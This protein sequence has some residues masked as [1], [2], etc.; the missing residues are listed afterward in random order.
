MRKYLIFLFF[1]NIVL[2][3]KLYYNYE[4]RLFIDNKEVKIKNGT[5]NLYTAQVSKNG[6]Y[7]AGFLLTH[8]VNDKIEHGKLKGGII[9]PLM[10]NNPKVFVVYDLECDSVIYKRILRNWPSG[11]FSEN[12]KYFFFNGPTQKQVIDLEKKK[13]IFSYEDGEYYWEYLVN[14]CLLLFTDEYYIR[15]DLEQNK[16]L[17]KTGTNL[18]RNIANLNQVLDS[19]LVVI[20]TDDHKYN[21]L[22][23]FK[24]GKVEVIY[25]ELEIKTTFVDNG[26]IY[27]IAKTSDNNAKFLY[28]YKSLSTLE[29]IIDIS[30]LTL[31]FYELDEKIN[32]KSKFKINIYF[33]LRN[34]WIKNDKLF[35]FVCGFPNSSL[36]QDIYSYDLKT[37]ELK[38]VSNKNDFL[39]PF[40]GFV[41]K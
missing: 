37:N 19:N 41:N 4:E 17:S 25:P 18:F 11:K 3:Q 36:P 8:A 35:F 33:D 5:E 13:V 31:K 23:K 22:A 26:E 16:I 9:E 7:A 39:G 21:R 14:N 40:M 6:K 32:G 38:N 24:N 28:K 20:D 10:N 2:G 29:K 30:E 15:Y 12:S 27:F 1:V 34:F